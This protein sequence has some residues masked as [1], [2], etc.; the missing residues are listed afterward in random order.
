[1]NETL[2]V[3]EDQSLAVLMVAVLK[4]QLLAP[5]AEVIVALYT[6]SGTTSGQ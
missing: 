5:G 3:E 6:S 1:M 2:S 4:D